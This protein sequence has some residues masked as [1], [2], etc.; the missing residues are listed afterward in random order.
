MIMTVD[1]KLKE[2]MERNPLRVWRKSHTPKLSLRRTAALLGVNTSSVQT[3][4]EG[5]GM[6]NAQNMTSIAIVTKDEDL[7]RRWYAWW[8]EGPN[9]R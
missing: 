1:D 6:P 7:P 3:W 5:S 2:W 4:E 9:V 8:A